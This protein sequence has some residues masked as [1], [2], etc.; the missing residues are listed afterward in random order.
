MKEWARKLADD[1]ALTEDDLLQLLDDCS[2]TVIEPGDEGYEEIE[3]M[4]ES[5]DQTK[6]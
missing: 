2:V 1:E 4:F 5:L 3:A 6:H